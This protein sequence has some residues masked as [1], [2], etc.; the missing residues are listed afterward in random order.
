MPDISDLHPSAKGVFLAKS[1][2]G[3]YEKTEEKTQLKLAVSV[4]LIDKAIHEYSYARNAVLVGE[5]ES[6]M[7]YEDINRRGQGQLIYGA[8]ITNHLE[9]CINALGRIYATMKNG[10]GSVSQTVKN[11]RNMVEHMDEKM[12]KGVY[13]PI[14]L[15]ISEDASSIKIFFRDYYTDKAEVLDLNTID[16]AEE[17][18]RLHTHILNKL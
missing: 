15:D 10:K 11:M 4:R 13:G 8:N 16:L 18:R 5:A 3:G 14:G 1:I 12:R 2:I 9:N 7:S 6:A 17:I